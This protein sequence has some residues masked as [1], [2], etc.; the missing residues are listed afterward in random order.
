MVRSVGMSGVKEVVSYKL[1]QGVGVEYMKF[2]LYSLVKLP[3]K[4]VIHA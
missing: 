3:H 4:S 1:K 2:L